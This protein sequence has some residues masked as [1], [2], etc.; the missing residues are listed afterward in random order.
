MRITLYNEKLYLNFKTMKKIT[1]ILFI[2]NFGFSCFIF[3]QSNYDTKY[4]SE[5]VLKDKA[6]TVLNSFKHYR[7]RDKLKFVKVSNKGKDNET[8]TEI[9]VF[10]NKRKV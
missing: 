5:Y 8:T 2:F 4:S 10:K 3:P 9:F 1:A 7:S 6:G